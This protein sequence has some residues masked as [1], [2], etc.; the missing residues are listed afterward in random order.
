M[1]PLRALVEEM[2]ALRAFVEHAQAPRE[3]LSLEDAAHALGGISRRQVERMVARHELA[4]VKI[5]RR[6][7]I[8]RAEV[9]RYATP[10]PASAPVA[11]SAARRLFGSC[12]RT[13]TRTLRPGV[14]C[15]VATSRPAATRA[16]TTL[17]FIAWCLLLP[18]VRCCQASARFI[19]AT[20]R[21]A[22]TRST[23]AS[24]PP[25]RMRRTGI[26]AGA[27]TGRTTSLGRPLA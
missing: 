1:D 8:P 17:R 10:P 13:P 22:S 18:F 2:R 27:R 9:V 3:L 25:R 15:G 24:A 4:T 26:G 5:G 11:R 19:P 6:T 20:D 16:T 12:L 21:R 23:S 7:M 14:G